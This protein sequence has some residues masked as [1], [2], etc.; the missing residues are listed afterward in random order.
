MIPSSRADP[1]LGFNKDKD[2][3][4]NNKDIVTPCRSQ[5][6]SK[7]F[8]R[9]PVNLILFMSNPIMCICKGPDKSQHRAQTH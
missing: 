1:V 2:K 6:L 3:T 7:G 9:I 8:N 4:K 5:N